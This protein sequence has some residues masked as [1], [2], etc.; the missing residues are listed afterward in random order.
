VA[1]LRTVIATSLCSPLVQLHG[2]RLRG[3]AACMAAHGSHAGQNGDR[4]SHAAVAHQWCWAAEKKML[5]RGK[6]PARR[7]PKRGGSGE[8]SP[9]RGG[10][11]DGEQRTGSFN[12]IECSSVDV[13]SARK[14]NG[15]AAAI[16]QGRRGK[17]AAAH[18]SERREETA[19][20][21]S[22]GSARKRLDSDAATVTCAGKTER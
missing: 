14:S 19:R 7:R 3:L 5:Q 8:A 12:G 4:G 10:R 6:T 18:S 9:T 11:I 22:V 17:M 16:R 13:L 21:A 1:C 15:E 2:P 20:P